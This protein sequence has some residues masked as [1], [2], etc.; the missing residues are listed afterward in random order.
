MS[1]KTETIYNFYQAIL[2]TFCQ[3]IMISCSKREAVV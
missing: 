2:K 3:K 1:V